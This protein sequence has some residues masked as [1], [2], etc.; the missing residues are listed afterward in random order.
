MD[1]TTAGAHDG[2]DGLSRR[3]ALKRGAV[4]GGAAL[5]MTPAVQVLAVSESSAEQPRG[6]GPAAGPG[7]AGPRGPAKGRPFG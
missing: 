5:W 1:D 7:K 6:V 2:G 4:L 3:Q